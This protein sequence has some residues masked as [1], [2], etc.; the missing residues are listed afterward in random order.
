MEDFPLLILFFIIYLVAGITGGRKAKSRTRGRQ[1]PVR[2]GGQGEQRDHRSAEGLRNAFPGSAPQAHAC[3]QQ[4]M[5][6]HEVS[7]EQ[8][9]YAAEGEDPCHVGDARMNSDQS[10]PAVHEQTKGQL[11]QDILRGVIMSEIL[12]RPCDRMAVRRG[13]R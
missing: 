2:T 11:E 4:R 7:G 10:E 1:G 3:D 13:R 12:T 8:L 9:Q 5:H 6:L